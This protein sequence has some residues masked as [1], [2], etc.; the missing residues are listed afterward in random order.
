MWNLTALDARTSVSG[1]VD[2]EL[3]GVFQT[4]N[5][6]KAVPPKGAY[7][8]SVE[9]LR[10]SAAFT[11]KHGSAQFVRFGGRGAAESALFLGLGAAGDLTE[12]KLR[13]VGG[14][15]WSKAI[16]EKSAKI[17]VRLD[18]FYTDKGMS[19]GLTPTKAARALAEG[20]VMGA[21]FFNIHKSKKEDPSFPA[22]IT[23][24]TANKALQAVMA[25][26]VKRLRALAG[27]V[28]VTRD[29]SNQPSNY[30]TPEYFAGEAKRLCKEYGLKCTVLSEKD[31]EKEKM[32]L[33]LAVGRGSEREGK[34]VVVEYTPSA[35]AMK[36]DPEGAKS[37][38][39][40]LVGKGVTFDSG[41]I[42][43][44]PSL[45]ME[46]MKHDMTGASTV[47]GATL[48]ASQL[49][50]RN[51]IVCIMAFTENMPDAD[52]VQP[53][54]VIVSRS[55]KT[56]EI[57]NTDA[58][59]RLILADALDFA[60]D[61]KPDAIVNAATLTGAVSIALGKYRCAIMGN[62]DALVNRIQ[63]SSVRAGEKL[64]QLPMDDEYFDDL[65]SET[66]DMKNAANDSYGGTIRGAIFMRQ[67]IR[68]G[69]PWAHLDI[70][71]VANGISYLSYVPKRG[72]SGLIVRTLAQFALDF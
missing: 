35:A 22:R 43:I 17:S 51:R 13:T 11:A 57:I 36:K 30:G 27:A 37:K 42:S 4:G 9:R 67:F 33:F 52:A 39:L 70:A 40:A 8:K 3:V 61:F 46:E 66:A 56:V 44:K 19:E 53:G 48:L 38:T 32:G 20:M 45:R 2:L 59:G 34:I 64:W 21:Y 68:K 72:A 31:A 14:L 12:E 65:R 69:M 1:K 10:K 23:F 62:D 71:A 7:A 15:A 28:Q 25:E 55:G 50:C 5:P 41:G 63:E 54:N 16:A 47:F 60:H 18:T 58:E 24:V 49:G 29:W 6:A 26:E